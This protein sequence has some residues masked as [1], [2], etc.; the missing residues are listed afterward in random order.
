SDRRTD[1]TES[2]GGMPVQEFINEAM[3]AI[4]ND[5]PETAIGTSKNSREKREELFEVMNNRWNDI[6]NAKLK[7]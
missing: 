4:R 1:K 2:H 3:N 5:I 6:K 7:G